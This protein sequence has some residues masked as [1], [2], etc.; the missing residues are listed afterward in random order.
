M[1]EEVKRDILSVLR[2]AEAAAIKRD[3]LHLKEISSH[4]V[5]NSSIFQDEDS[6]SIAVVIYSLSKICERNDSS[7]DAASRMLKHARVHLQKDEIHRYKHVI[8]KLAQF[9]SRLDSKFSIYV[10]DVF[11]QAE[12]KKGSRLYYHGISLGQSASLLGVSQWELM[13]YVG[14][15][16]MIDNSERIGNVRQRIGFARKLFSK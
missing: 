3:S 6:I 5:H 2:D 4:T 13:S 1:I 14:K 7:L 16:Q 10:Q 9:I 8:R 15:T 12:I 11:D